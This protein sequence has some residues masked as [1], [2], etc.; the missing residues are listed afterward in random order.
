[1]FDNVKD[2]QAVGE[3]FARLLAREFPG[4][5]SAF[6]CI[7]TEEGPPEETAPAPAPT[8]APAPEAPPPG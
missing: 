4:V 7:S 6:I 3:F 2:C 5:Q 8:E 1:M